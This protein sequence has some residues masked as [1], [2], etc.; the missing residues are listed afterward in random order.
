MSK[1]PDVLIAGGG[2]IG[3]STAYFLAREG[4]R[5]MLV[6]QGDLG[7]EASW[8]GAGILPPGD[9][10]AAAD[11]V[12]KLRAHG[13]A[14]HRSLAEELRQRTGIDNGYE[15]CGGV[16]LPATPDAAPDAEWLG[17]EVS[18]ERLEAA[19]LRRVEPALTTAAGCG[20]FLPGMAQVRNPRH[21]KALIAACRSLGVDLRPHCA[22]HELL[23]RGEQVEGL[24][25]SAGDL[26]A[27]QVLLATGAWTDRLLE[28]TGWRPGIRPIRGQIALLN[29]GE[30]L[31]RRIVLQGPRYVVPRSDGRVLVGS[32]EEDVGFDRRTTAEA[33]ASLLRLGA[34]LV[35][36]LA[37]ASVERCWAGLRPGSPDG[38]PF[39]GRVPGW[40]NLFVA[41]GHF[42]SGILLSPITAQLMK[43]LL[44][45]QPLTL[46]LEAFRPERAAT[47]VPANG[48]HQS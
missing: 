1:Q 18:C 10:E 36:A 34:S 19:G 42:R 20:W 4:A 3:L 39:L 6:D 13:A 48:E 12:G 25:T 32:T 43:E 24:R 5:V 7:Q 9:V 21:L 31:L 29:T 15:R 23:L 8:A 17:A 47:I 33:I 27:A 16:E 14:M 2:V 38:L 41:A 37:G 28:Q 11:Q 30:L 26:G 44:L 46:P 45:G 40:S 22:V 35:P